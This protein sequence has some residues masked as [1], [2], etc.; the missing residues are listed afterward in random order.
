MQP[1]HDLGTVVPMGGAGTAVLPLP[2]EPCEPL[3]KPIA[4]DEYA[5][6]ISQPSSPG[7]RTRAARFLSELHVRT[8]TRPEGPGRLAPIRGA[9]R[10]SVAQV[11]TLG[12]W[13]AASM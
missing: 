9:Q 13:W 11:D 8:S 2:F 1:Y 7:W 4:S 6:T 10:Q 3:R 5:L 12:G